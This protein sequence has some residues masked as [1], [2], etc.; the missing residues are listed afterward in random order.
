M[1][2]LPSA[3]PPPSLPLL[4]PPPAQGAAA[5]AVASS[6]STALVAMGPQAQGGASMAFQF[7]SSSASATAFASASVNSNAELRR[8]LLELLD[9]EELAELKFLSS[10]DALGSFIGRCAGGAPRVCGPRA[11]ADSRRPG[12]EWPRRPR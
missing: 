2:V 1:A 6:S 7:S 8:S 10:Y 3:A 4:L 5:A 12:A 11:A 9:P